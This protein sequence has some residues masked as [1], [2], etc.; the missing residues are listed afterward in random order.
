MVPGAGNPQS[1]NRYAYVFNNPLKYTDPS[2]HC[3]K[4]DGKDDEED[5]CQ[6]AIGDVEKN[7]KNI[8]VNARRW[9]IKELQLVLKALAGHP[10]SDD[11]R[12]A[13]QIDLMRSDRDPDS[14][15]V[16]GVTESD[17]RLDYTVT[18]YDFAWWAR[19]DA[20]GT[21]W[22]NVWDE[23]FMGTVV[24]EFT[25]LASAMNPTIIK[26]FRAA[27]GSN[28]LFSSSTPIGQGA[29]RRL[30]S[31]SES[32]RR[33]EL[34]AMTVAANQITPKTFEVSDLW[35]GGPYYTHWM[36]KWAQAWSYPSPSTGPR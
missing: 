8:K 11:I 1:L 15:S 19:P 16:A 26:T 30:A 28:P 35:W 27:E 25:H 17:N 20:N 36:G 12:S 3:G 31:M 6:K 14:D 2:G 7:Y 13:R 29:R 24:H 9:T 34:M 18:I 32:E 23:N 33:E 10:F 4:A 22:L 21:T 5:E